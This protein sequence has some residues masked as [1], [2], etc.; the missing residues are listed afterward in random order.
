MMKLIFFMVVGI[1]EG[2]ALWYFVGYSVFIREEIKKSLLY[3]NEKYPKI[4]F[5]KRENENLKEYDR[6]LSMIKWTSEVIEDERE[7]LCL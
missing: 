1:F 3:L 7:K 6:R 2:I 4:D 5:S